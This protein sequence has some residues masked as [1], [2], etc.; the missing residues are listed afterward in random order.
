M[1]T[2]RLLPSAIRG[3]HADESAGSACK[4]QVEWFTDKKAAPEILFLSRLRPVSSG[5]VDLFARTGIRSIV[6]HFKYL[7]VQKLV[8]QRAGFGHFRAVF[9]VG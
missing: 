4:Q 7:L 6:V 8:A 2:I 5:L 1:K 9:P 3:S